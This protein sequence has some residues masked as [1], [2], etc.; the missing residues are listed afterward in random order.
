MKKFLLLGLLAGSN[1][2][3]FA[4]LSPLSI[5]NIQAGDSIVVKYDATINNPLVPPGTTQISNQGT[6][7]GGN[8]SN[9]LTD[10]PDTGP[11][12]DPT[13]TLLNVFPLPVTLTELRAVQTGTGIVL[14]W[15]VT[16]EYNLEKY[17]IERST[18][19]RTFV[20]I[21]EVAGRNLPGILNYTFTDIQPAADNNYYRLRMVDT[22]G[23]KKYSSIVKVKLGGQA[24]AITVFPN[25]VTAKALTIQLQNMKSGAYT[26]RLFNAMG[27]LVL[28]KQFNHT[29]GASSQALYLPQ[30]ISTGY[31]Q[32]EISGSESRNS[33]RLVI[34]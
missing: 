9:V 25:P 28:Q 23:K 6:C 13:I 26:V 8:F 5:G 32:L 1:T 4:Q 16:D 29:G 30:A 14:Q 3:L 15:K 21:G 33:F 10:D 27:Q 11:A 17:V 24:P 18:D 20:P 12:N 7:S 34:Q 19:G 22:D 31:Y 2:L